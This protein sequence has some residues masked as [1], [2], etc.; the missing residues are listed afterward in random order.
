MIRG[1]KV[2][3]TNL[4]R[5]NKFKRIMLP[6]IKIYYKAKM[7]KLEHL[8]QTMAKRRNGAA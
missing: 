8:V 3:K 2:T 5:K 7:K 1:K 4:K 6:P